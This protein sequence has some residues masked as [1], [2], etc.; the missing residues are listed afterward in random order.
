MRV[1]KLHS[2]KVS[3]YEAIEIQKRLSKRI[4]LGEFK[5]EIKTIAGCDA[6]FKEDKIYG[7]V[8]VFSF[9]EFKLLEMVKKKLVCK[10]PYIPGLLSFREGP[11]FVS[12]FKT[13]KTK[14]DLFI[15]DGQG[16]A[17]PRKMGLATHLGILLNKP[18]IGCAKN[19]LVGRYLLSN[20]GKKK[21]SHCWLKDER[22]E[23][24]GAVLRTRENVKPVFVSC[25]YKI[26]LFTALRIILSLCK[27]Y[28][29]PEPL[30]MA[31]REAKK[32]YN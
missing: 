26:D 12:C 13:I 11:V 6:W 28:R 15:F 18:S 17:H 21:G 5:G 1:L 14:P 7:V 30:R 32:I 22:G 9:P 24:V 31:H 20:L 23:I 3:P 10:F 16:I 29:I 19:I 8:C 2:W 4:K 27:K 25:G